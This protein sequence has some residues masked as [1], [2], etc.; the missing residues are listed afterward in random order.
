MTSVI[1]CSW[2][3]KILRIIE[4]S[5]TNG[6]D[7]HGIC[8]NCFKQLIIDLK[9]HGEVKSEILKGARNGNKESA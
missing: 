1:K 4:E 6:L 8:V 9:Q 3:N 7:S 2:C 5:Y